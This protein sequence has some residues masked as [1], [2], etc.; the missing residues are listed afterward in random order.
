MAIEVAPGGSKTVYA[1][2]GVW[3]NADQDRIH[4]TIPGSGWFHST[5]SND[6]ASKRYHP[7]LFKKLRRLLEQEG[8]WPS[9]D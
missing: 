4:L 7:N 2:F 6:P 8:R 1:R 3:Y 9:S 5:V